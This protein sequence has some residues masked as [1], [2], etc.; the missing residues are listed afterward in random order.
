MKFYWPIVVSSG[1]FPLHKSASMI[2]KSKKQELNM[3]PKEVA[4]DHLL[5]YDL[6]MSGQAMQLPN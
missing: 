6:L 1:N 5:Q 2:H 4:Q 3:L